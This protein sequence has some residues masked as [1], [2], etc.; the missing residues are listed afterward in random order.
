MTGSTPATRFDG[1]ATIRTA[2][3]SHR[4]HLRVIGLIL[5]A[6]IIFFALMLW[7]VTLGAVPLSI[8]EV[9]D[10]TFNRGDD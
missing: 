3:F 7:S 1:H 10:A 2:G 6:A 4:F 5:L 8:P 9:W